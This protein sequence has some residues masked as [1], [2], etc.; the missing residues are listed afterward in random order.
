MFHSDWYGVD[1]VFA[2]AYAINNLLKSGKTYSQIY[3][4][5]YLNA[6]KAATFNGTTGAFAFDSNYDRR[7]FVISS[8][9]PQIILNT[10]HRIWD[11]YNNVYNNET[12]ELTVN[13]IG[14]Y[15][16]YASQL[17]VADPEIYFYGGSTAVPA[18]NVTYIKPATNSTVAPSMYN[19]P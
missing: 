3:G 15:R 18:A 2:H 13:W 10:Y 14:E 9:L 17:Y 1:S 8:S 16:W 11:V 4:S 19:G 6:L 12:G 5:T 7:G